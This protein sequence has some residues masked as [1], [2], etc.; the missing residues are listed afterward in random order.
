MARYLITNGAAKGDIV[1]VLLDKSIDI[2][3]SI[4]GILKIGATFLPIDISYPQERIEYI[5]D[6]SKSKFVITNKTIS[7][8]NAL[9]ISSEINS[10]SKENLNVHFSTNHPAYIMYTSGSTG[11]PK[12]VIVTNTN[13][14]RLVKNNTFI[15]LSSFQH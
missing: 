1:S 9:I 3:I 5:L 4:L 13:V 12:G 11:K 6:D 7:L 2:I 14:V 15:K 8:K 10:F